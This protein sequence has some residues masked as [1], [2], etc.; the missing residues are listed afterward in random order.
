MTAVAHLSRLAGKTH[1][2]VDPPL[3]SEGRE[4]TNLTSCCISSRAER[5][6]SI[7]DHNRTARRHYQAARLC[8]TGATSPCWPWR[9]HG[10]GRRRRSGDR[11]HRYPA[12]RHRRDG[13][14][15]DHAQAGAEM[16]RHLLAG[17]PPD[18]VEAVAHAIAATVSA[19]AAPQTLEAKIVHDA[20]KLDAIGAWA[21]RGRLPT[22]V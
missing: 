12:T 2:Y 15:T 8:M 14:H 6:R 7:Y 13:S 9:A 17:H 11:A 21:W 19:V 1:R 4:G 20:D 3:P 18:R 16:A 5:A 10:Q 22:A